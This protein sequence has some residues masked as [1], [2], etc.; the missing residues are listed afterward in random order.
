MRILIKP[1]IFVLSAWMAT[2]T[3]PAFAG[4]IW[5]Q[6]SGN[7][8]STATWAGGVAPGS[9]DNAYIGS[10][11]APGVNNATVTLQAAESASG[12]YVGY[13]SPSN[14]VLNLNGHTLTI[15]NALTIGDLGGTGTVNENGGSFSAG[16]LDMYTGGS[17]FTFGSADAVANIDIENG[18]ALST[19]ATGNIT[20]GGNIVA[21]G[22]VNL[23]ANTS[24]SG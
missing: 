21:G 15:T 17:S 24:M 4:I 5:A 8:E 22:V 14:G 13:G 23:G 16:G 2:L 6:A 19:V 7:W 11:Q 3:A 12:V 10:S 18:A 20:T 1:F 9:A